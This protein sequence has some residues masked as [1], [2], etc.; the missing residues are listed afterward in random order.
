MVRQGDEKLNGIS[1]AS[2]FLGAFLC[3][4]N[5]WKV[6]NHPLSKQ[7]IIFTTAAKSLRCI[8]IDFSLRGKRYLK[9]CSGKSRLWHVKQ[10][11]IQGHQCVKWICL[12]SS[13]GFQN[14]FWLSVDI[15]SSSMQAVVQQMLLS[16]TTYSTLEQSHW[17][18]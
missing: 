8:C 12:K 17:S 9:N 4:S 1:G 2:L 3:I 15:T 18:N 16:E 5:R 6:N 13:L 11:T 14:Y 7:N 10:K